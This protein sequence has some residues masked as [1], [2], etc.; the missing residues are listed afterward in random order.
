MYNFEDDERTFVAVKN[1]ALPRGWTAVPS[2]SRPGEAR[3]EIRAKLYLSDPW[4]LLPLLPFL[5][6]LL[7]L[8]FPGNLSTHT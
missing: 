2:K 5:L 4:L 3:N 7:R 8:F 1:D 6:T